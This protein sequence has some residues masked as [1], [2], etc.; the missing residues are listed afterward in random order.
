MSL[1]SEVP[2]FMSETRKR[3]F[4]AAVCRDMNLAT[5]LER[6]PFIDCNFCDMRYPL[7][8]DEEE[9]VLVGS[10]LSAA[11]QNLDE[12]GWKI[13]SEREK[14]LRPATG[15]RIRF[16]LSSLRAKILRLSLGNRMEC[17]TKQHLYVN[18]VAMS[19]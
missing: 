15:I 2:F 9:I 3:I 17:M 7:D 11:L 6:P 13:S 8:L 19:S 18:T 4:A 1:Q 12:S 10:E 16:A 5:L 14:L